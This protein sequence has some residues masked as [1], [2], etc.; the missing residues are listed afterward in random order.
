MSEMAIW[1]RDY[2]VFLPVF[3]LLLIL[4]AWRIVV[5]ANKQ[6]AYAVRTQARSWLG[7]RWDGFVRWL[8]S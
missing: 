4:V 6:Q 8:N 2:I 5:R 1:I 7:E 3:I